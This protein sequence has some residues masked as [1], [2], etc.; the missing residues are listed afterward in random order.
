MSELNDSNNNSNRAIYISNSNSTNLEEIEQNDTHNDQSAIIISSPDI[1]P[2]RITSGVTINFA[3]FTGFLAPQTNN[4][5]GSSSSGSWTADS[6]SNE[7]GY[8][9]SSSALIST[10]NSSIVDSD[11]ETRGDE[12]ERTS[13]NNTSSPFGI[14]NYVRNS[15]ADFIEDLT[16]PSFKRNEDNAELESNNNN[17]NKVLKGDK[18]E[19]G[20]FYFYF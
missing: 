16:K 18:E 11:S 1:S 9:S 20:Q 14:E 19:V 15:Q 2:T 5:F 13:L 8:R 10:T 3:N 7:A 17:T 4:V 12:S 6:S